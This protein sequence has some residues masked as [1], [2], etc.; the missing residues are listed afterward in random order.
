VHQLTT[1]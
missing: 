1:R